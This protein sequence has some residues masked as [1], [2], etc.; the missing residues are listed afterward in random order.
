[1]AVIPHPPLKG[2]P[3]K[4][5]CNSSQNLKPGPDPET[6]CTCSATRRL[7]AGFPGLG[8]QR[9][10]NGNGNGNGVGERE[11]GRALAATRP[12]STELD[13]GSWSWDPRGPLGRP[14]GARR[15]PTAAAIHRSRRRSGESP[16][17]R[18]GSG[19]LGFPNVQAVTSGTQPGA[20]AI[21]QRRASA[22]RAPK[23]R[24]P[25]RL[26]RL[27]ARERLGSARLGLSSAP[28][29]DSAASLARSLADPNRGPTLTGAAAEL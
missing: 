17:P 11:G 25:A 7:P 20:G 14:G 6:R 29:S 2:L 3:R 4:E 23:P 10:G 8:H 26:S 28:G 12:P 13:P 16:L 5:A 15:A 27:A 1:M 24:G 22:P 21:A 19:P 18:K 9:S